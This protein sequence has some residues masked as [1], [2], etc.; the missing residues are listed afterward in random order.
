MKERPILFNGEMVRAILDGR[1]TQTRRLV[2][3]DFNE[4]VNGTPWFED[5]EGVSRPIN[6]P[7][8]KPCDRLWVRETW[9]DA[10]RKFYPHSRVVFRASDDYLDQHADSCRMEAESAARRNLDHAPIEGC[11]CEFKWKPSIHMPKWASRIT[12]EITDVRVERLNDIS[13]ADAKAEGI[14]GKDTVTVSE[15][16]TKTYKKAFQIYWDNISKKS[17]KDKVHPSPFRWKENPWVWVV[18]FKRVT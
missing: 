7:F 17:W 2:K 14:G 4:I 12:L 16:T 5:E 1:K 13:E 8:G 9:S 15:Y 11:A 6:N 18:E 10:A 3:G